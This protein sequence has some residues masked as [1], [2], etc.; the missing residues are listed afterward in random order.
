MGFFPAGPARPQGP[1]DLGGI[2]LATL[3]KGGCSICPLNHQRGL[4]HPQMKPH[5]ATKPR[6][7]MLGEAPGEKEDEKGRPFVGPAGSM[8]RQHMPDKWRDDRIR[9][10]N[11]VRTRPPDNRDPAPVEIE[12]CRPSIVA[13]VEEAAPEAIFGFGNVPLHWATR[14]T[15]ISNWNGRR[16]PVRIGN[17]T[18]WYFPM[19]HPSFILH[20]PSRRSAEE[21]E[22]IFALNLYQAFEAVE[23]GLPKPVV[24]TPERALANVEVV[25]GSGGEADVKRVVELIRGLYDEKT[26]GLDYETKRLRPYYNDSRILSV[27]L[28]SRTSTFA[29]PVDHPGGWKKTRYRDAVVD[30]YKRFLYEAPTIKIA[31]QLAFEHEW[32]GWTFGRDCIR[33]GWED[34]ASQ[35]YILDERPGHGKCHSLNFLCVQ[36][37]GLPIKDL[38]RLD[39]DNLDKAPIR[40]VLQYNAV[41]A[42]YCRFLH[43]PQMQRLRDECLEVVYRRHMRRIPTMVLTQMKGIPIDQEVVADFDEKFTKQKAK[44]EAEIA[45]ID[46]VQLFAKKKGAPFNPGS[47]PDIMYVLNRLL[48]LGVANCDESILK[49]LKH[50]FAKTILRYRNVTKLHSTYVKCLMLGSSDLHPDG[51]IRPFL[52]TTKTRT[53]RTSS[54]QPNSQNFPKRENKELRSQ[55]RK[56]GHKVVSFDYGQIQ[57]R[58]VGMESRDP[59]LVKAFWDHYDIHTAWTEIIVKLYP[60][61]IKEGAKTLATD[62]KLF[63][64]YRDRTKNELV[65]PSFF[66]AQATSVARYLGIPDNIAKELHDRFWDRF[67]GIRNWHR[68]LEANYKKTGYVTGHSGFRRR[69]PISPNELINAPIQADE[70]LIVCDAMARLSELGPEEYQANME[71]HDDLTFI[72]PTEK[73]DEYSE[74]VIRE[75]LRIEYDWINVPLVVDRSIGDDW[76][77]KEGAGRFETKRDGSY[78]EI[79]K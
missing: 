2:S 16:I 36:Y 27:G 46:V 59:V 69:G 7:Y 32:S 45:A 19:L 17:H 6:V 11:V 24:H 75:M 23:A 65:F 55:V 26:A 61:W 77:F 79:K 56:R 48:L 50:P 28:S 41:D 20:L 25:D 52:A 22:F 4:H 44:I 57:A 14:Q 42:R 72:W 1:R 30:E 29:F 43:F 13:D 66:G 73:V 12:C 31:H 9:W 18:C 64:K 33:K 8:L 39:K 70:S 68:R 74:V 63:E 76:A 21:W 10:N 58:N 15:T 40:D 3:H 51:L 38:H 34:T 54:E 67:G 35:A 37:F 71:I 53:W 78:Y 62:P 47:N 49:P 60:A 5:G